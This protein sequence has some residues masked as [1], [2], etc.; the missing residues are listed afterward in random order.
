MPTTTEVRLTCSSSDTH[1]TQCYCLDGC[2]SGFP[3][4]D[5]RRMNSVRPQDLR[6]ETNNKTNLVIGTTTG[7]GVS[8]VASSGIAAFGHL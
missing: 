5:E 3:E 7:V 6:G 2:S 4:G 8:L 1:A